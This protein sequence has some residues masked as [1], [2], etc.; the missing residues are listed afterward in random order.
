MAEG[1]RLFASAIPI[2]LL[3]DEFGF[4]VGYKVIIIVLTVLTVIYTYLGGIKAVIW[5]DAIQMLLYVG[6]AILAICV[7]LGSRRRQR[8]LRCPA[9][10][11]V[12]GL[13]HQLR[14]SRT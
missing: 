3:L 13:R 4:H 10:R 2:K 9:R 6:G 1:V 7:L 5:T 11:Q 12:Q 8:L 14:R